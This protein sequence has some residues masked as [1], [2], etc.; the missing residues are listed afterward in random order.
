MRSPTRGH[1]KYGEYDPYG[2]QSGFATVY[3]YEL[4]DLEKDPFELINIYNAS[5][6]ELKAWLHSTVR[7]YYECAGPNCM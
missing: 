1:L 5:S 7:A 4:F 3:F 6:T 2:K